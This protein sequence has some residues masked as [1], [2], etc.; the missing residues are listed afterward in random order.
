MSFAE[1]QP[2]F[3]FGVIFSK[4]KERSSEAGSAL[5]FWLLFFQEKSNN[6]KKKRT[7]F[8]ANINTLKQKER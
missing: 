2:N 4:P 3:T 6:N 8:A 5:N 1:A 7:I